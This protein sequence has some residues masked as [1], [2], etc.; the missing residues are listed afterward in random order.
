MRRPINLLYNAGLGSK[1]PSEAL[2]CRLGSIGVLHGLESI[3]PVLYKRDNVYLHWERKM[4]L[5]E[6]AILS[7]KKY[8]RSPKILNL[9]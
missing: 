8:F 4:P 7:P 3:E 5:L 1:S 6:L 9:K 2:K